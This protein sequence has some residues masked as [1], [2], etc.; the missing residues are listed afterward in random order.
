M[1]GFYKTSNHNIVLLVAFFFC[2]VTGLFDFS[3]VLNTTMQRRGV[4]S[5]VSCARSLLQGSVASQSRNLAEAVPATD[6]KKTPL[7]D[8]H[9]KNGGELSRSRSC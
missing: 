9:L 6:L 2:V 8:F 4:L 3:N 5:L 7:F 1:F